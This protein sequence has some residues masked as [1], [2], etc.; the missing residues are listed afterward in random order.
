MNE[1]GA[2]TYQEI[3]SQPD[4]WAEAIAVGSSAWDALQTLWSRSGRGEL[5][6]TGCGSTYYLSLAAAAMARGAGL[7][8]RA[9]PASEIWLYP[10]HTAPN[11]AHNVLVA[12]SR[13]GE[14]SETLRAVEGYRRAGGRTVIDVTCY[15][16]AALS[17]LSDLVLAIPSAQEVSVAQ[18]RSFASM[19]V[20][21][22][23]L[24]AALAGDAA[25]PQRIGALPDLGRR[26]IARYASLATDLGARESIQR[27]FF[28][29]NGPLY[30][31]ACEAML[32]M[33]EMSLSYSEA[34]HALEFRHGPKSMANEA[35]LVVS[36]LSDSAW[37]QET[38]VTA[39]M[40]AL[41]AQTL[42][43][44]A[45]CYAGAD[46]AVCLESGLALADR[47]V[48][49]LPVLQLLAFQR[50]LTNSQDPDAP[51]NLTA[52]VSL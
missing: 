29:G 21:C 7:P 45:Q 18:T 8:A 4:A 14:T 22:R 52:V 12:V 43:I 49:Y 46:H 23:L 40:R 15:P 5:L 38:A 35:S 30:G 37:A 16:D 41:G 13:S 20:M 48:L 26:L 28:L 33:K 50:A 11:L 17:G 27:F 2:H 25:C 9:A 44:G 34:Y 19:L 39:D 6:F 24:V 10:E 3:L 51:H 32:K 47:L 1:H 31:M 36:L 42:A